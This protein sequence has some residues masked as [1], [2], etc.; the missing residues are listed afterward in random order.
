MVPEM[1]PQSKFCSSGRG[2]GG[3]GIGEGV[4]IIGQLLIYPWVMGVYG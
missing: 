1:E 2:E 3:G 4:L